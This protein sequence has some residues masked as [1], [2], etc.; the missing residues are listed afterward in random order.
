[1]LVIQ[2]SILSILPVGKKHLIIFSIGFG[3]NIIFYKTR[4]VY[5]LIVDNKAIKRIDHI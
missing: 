3:L 5:Y 1:M 4:L 2:R